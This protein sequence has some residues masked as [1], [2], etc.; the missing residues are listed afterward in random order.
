M[1]FLFGHLVG[2]REQ[3]LRYV[4][5]KGFCSLRFELDRLCITG[6]SAGGALEN[7]VAVDARRIGSRRDR[8]A[9][10]GAEVPVDR[11]SAIECQRQTILSLVN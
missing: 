6:I 5:A 11:L 7:L 1:A 10:V 3:V 9:A 8:R 4:D 2:D